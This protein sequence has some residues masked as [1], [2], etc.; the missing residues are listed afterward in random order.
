MY[1]LIDPKLHV[2]SS[3]RRGHNPLLIDN[4][5]TSYS[6]TPQR[7]RVDEV[8]LI[9]LVNQTTRSNI[10]PQQ[11]SRVN[12]SKSPH[13]IV[14]FLELEQSYQE[15][16]QQR[17]MNQ[18]KSS[19][20]SDIPDHLLWA[21]ERKIRQLID[22]KNKPHHD[23]ACKEHSQPK[24]A[25]VQ[26]ESLPKIGHQK[27]DQNNSN[28]GDEII[29][30]A[31]YRPLPKASNLIKTKKPY[32]LEEIRRK[33][34]ESS[35]I[36][37]PIN[38]KLQNPLKNM[39]VKETLRYLVNTSKTPQ[40]SGLLAEASN[41]GSGFPDLNLRE[42]KIYRLRDSLVNQIKPEFNKFKPLG[43]D[44]GAENENNERGFR[45][46]EPSAGI[47]SKLSLFENTKTKRI[48]IALVSS[49]YEGRS[50]SL[51]IPYPTQ[52]QKKNDTERIQKYQLVSEEMIPTFIC[53]NGTKTVLNILENAQLNEEQNPRFSIIW[54]R[55][56]DV[57]F[58][59]R[60][61]G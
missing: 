4:P 44:S 7:R 37:G 60:M 10:Q 32:R 17:L 30:G 9:P 56:P 26:F 24:P 29:T 33:S 36:E 11:Y 58:L 49:I 41:E 8:K 39:Q 19:M 53:E 38:M 52:C 28:D 34:S 16:K 13:C 31:I 22:F 55:I 57:H 46:R 61:L 14:D 15:T 27:R 40:Q 25:L 35:Q 50:C 43:N 59:N 51:Y 1:S 12:R 48:T 54:G 23:R 42:V 47:Y 20:Q 18:R 45:R 2:P 6:V 3:Y 21:N 5:S